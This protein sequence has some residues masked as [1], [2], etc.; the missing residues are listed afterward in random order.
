MIKRLLAMVIVLV[1]LLALI[2]YPVSAKAPEVHLFFGS[3]T[4]YGEACPGSVVEARVEDTMVGTAEVGLESTYFMLV[5]QI[6]GVLNGTTISFY[7]DD[8]YA[9][10][11]TWFMGGNTNLDLAVSAALADNTGVV[12]GLASIKDKLVS[13]CSYK[14]GEGS[15]GWTV[16]NPSWPA[17]ANT[18][19]TLYRQRG[20]WI[21]VIDECVLIYGLNYYDLDEGWNLIGW[22][23]AG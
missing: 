8:V 12:T 15:D 16:Y 13:V 10:T 4:L 11:D 6:G 5:P 18:L 1:V 23:G 3:V 19:T 14:S 22:V 17:E 21:N 2:P 9:G 7:V 20:Y